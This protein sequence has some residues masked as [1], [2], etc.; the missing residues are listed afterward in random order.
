[1]R[2]KRAENRQIQESQRKLDNE[3]MAEEEEEEEEMTDEEDESDDELDKWNEDDERKQEEGDSE[4]DGEDEE[5]KKAKNDFL[6]DE[7]DESDNDDDFDNG[8]DDIDSGSEGDVSDDGENDNTADENS[9]LS[10]G[11]FSVLKSHHSIKKKPKQTKESTIHPKEE[12]MDLFG[13]G[14]SRSRGPENDGSLE[15]NSNSEKGTGE[16]VESLCLRLDSLED[17]DDTNFHFPSSPVL[18]K[19]KAKNKNVANISEASQESSQSSFGGGLGSEFGGNVNSLEASSDSNVIPPGQRDNRVL[20]MDEDRSPGK[21]TPEIF[22]SFS[23]VRHLMS[24]GNY[25]DALSVKKSGKLS[26]LTLPVED[27]QDL[28]DHESDRNVEDN[29]SQLLKTGSEPMSSDFNF[30]LDEDT[31]FTQIL[32]TQGLVLPSLEVLWFFLFSD[33]FRC[34]G[35]H[36]E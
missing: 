4:V 7:T 22:L 31:Q 6:D 3:E 27:S 35:V 12:T 33:S 36:S 32:N 18:S 1:M 25:G 14:D 20:G 24:M 26:Q 16:S 2:V 10:D 17:G 13:F 34:T 11:E 23:R 19:M 5:D 8:R 28:F 9:V 21:K 30:S 15:N 29:N